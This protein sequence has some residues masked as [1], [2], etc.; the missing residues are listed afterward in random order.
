M[1]LG[2]TLVEAVRREV[3][4]EVGLDVDVIEFLLIQEAIFTREFWKKRHFIFFD[5]YCRCDSD[6]VKLDQKEL[7]EYAWVYPGEAFT[8]DLDSF[9]KKT[10]E[11]YLARN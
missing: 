2:E 10:L 4:E 6:K 8:M 1:E 7:Q 9:T 3:K 5:Y 11:K